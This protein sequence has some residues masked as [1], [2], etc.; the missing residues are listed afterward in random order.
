MNI[1]KVILMYRPKLK[2]QQ[3]PKL[4]SEFQEMLTSRTNI[5]WWKEKKKKHKLERITHVFTIY[6]IGDK[7]V[8][9]KSFLYLT[10]DIESLA[11]VNNQ[12]FFTHKIPER[13]IAH[14]GFQIYILDS[15]PSLLVP[16]SIIIYL[17][18]ICRQS[19]FDFIQNC[20]KRLMLQ[21]LEIPFLLI[22]NKLDKEKEREVMQEIRENSVFGQITNIQYFE[23]SCLDG[24]GLHPLL[25]QL[26]GLLKE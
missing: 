24:T 17:Y 8:G 20:H 13:T 16:S 25:S 22:G 19:S 15:H 7:Q 23:I 21:L 18:D 11:T 14:Y 2:P 10:S 12:Y 5:V 26:E 1:A 9:K 3:V 4:Q 6:I